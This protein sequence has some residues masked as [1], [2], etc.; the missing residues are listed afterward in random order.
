MIFRN[1]YYDFYARNVLKVVIFLI[2]H[3]IKIWRK[4]IWQ[5]EP[6]TWMLGNKVVMGCK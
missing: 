4:Q 3:S 2:V 6:E 1:I 5:L